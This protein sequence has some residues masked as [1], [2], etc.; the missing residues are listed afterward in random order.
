MAIEIRL[1]ILTL[2][3]NSG[4]ANVIP[5]MLFPCK[6]PRPD[7]DHDLRKLMSGTANNEEEEED[8]AHEDEKRTSYIKLGRD[9]FPL[10]EEGP[11]PK[12]DPFPRRADRP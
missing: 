2:T 10:P 3:R 8:L 11:L 12:T 4:I 9:I 7:A 5:P 6:C 1:A